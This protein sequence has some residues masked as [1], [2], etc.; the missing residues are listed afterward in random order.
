MENEVLEIRLMEKIILSVLRL[1]RRGRDEEIA[2]QS[3]PPFR[4]LIVEAA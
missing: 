4:N 1:L 3:F 2:D